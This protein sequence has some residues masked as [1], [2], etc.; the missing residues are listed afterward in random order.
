MQSA[1]QEPS[2]PPVDLPA[3]VIRLQGCL[4]ESEQQRAA[5]ETLLE[6][7]AQRIEQLLDCITLLRRKR[8]GR[9][10]DVVSPDQLSLFDEAELEAL[11]D[12]LEAEIDAAGETPAPPS[13]PEKPKKKPVRR[14][15]PAHLPRVTR[16][17]DLCEAEKQ[18]MPR[19]ITQVRSARPYWASI[20]FRNSRNVVL[21]LV[22]PGM[23]S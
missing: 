22:L 15:L 9:S 18:S 4:A 10:A 19:S 21:S 20:F 17:V 7:R 3:E 13:P 6:E 8:F 5:Q 23:T 12:E 16:T 1:I 2:T 11:I 14:P